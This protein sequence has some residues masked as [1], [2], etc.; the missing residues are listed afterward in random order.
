MKPQIRH[1]P[2]CGKPMIENPPMFY[3][4]DECQ[5]QLCEWNKRTISESTEDKIRESLKLPDLK[6]KLP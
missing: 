1:C 2:K 4:C 5:V 6:P 3:R